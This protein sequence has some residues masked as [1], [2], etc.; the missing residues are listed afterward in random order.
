[1]CAAG[2]EQRFLLCFSSSVHSEVFI[3]DM[4]IGIANNCI[5]GT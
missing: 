2:R 5:R 1:M 4:V 3:W